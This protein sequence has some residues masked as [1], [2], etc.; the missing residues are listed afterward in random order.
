[1][2]TFSFV[3]A[4]FPGGRPGAGYHL[5]RGQKKL[6]EEKAAPAS[7]HCRGVPVLLAVKSGCGTR[8]KNEKTRLGLRAQ[9]G[10]RRALRTRTLV[11][12]SGKERRRLRL[13]VSTGASSSAPA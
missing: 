4:F 10:S 8:S 13:S 3:H 9:T 2:V 7:R 1:M 6:T 5:L 12:W 11:E